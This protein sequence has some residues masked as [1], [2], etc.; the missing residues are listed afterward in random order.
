MGKLA[1]WNRQENE[2]MGRLRQSL[3]AHFPTPTDQ[4]TGGQHRII[5]EFA[6]RLPENRRVAFRAKVMK[7]L[8]AGGYLNDQRLVKICLDALSIS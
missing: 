3:E 7:G 6:D 2:M 4:L 8:A 5:T 1:S